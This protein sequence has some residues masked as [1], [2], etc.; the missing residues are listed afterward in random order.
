M[1]GQVGVKSR[2]AEVQS[3]SGNVILVDANKNQVCEFNFSDIH[4][5]IFYINFFV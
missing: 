4:I 2:T 1:W 3:K 5:Y